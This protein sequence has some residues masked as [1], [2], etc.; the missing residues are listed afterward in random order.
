MG[1]ID[2]VCG[3]THVSLGYIVARANQFDDTS[4]SNVDAG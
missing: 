1:F 2:D 4:R 3:I